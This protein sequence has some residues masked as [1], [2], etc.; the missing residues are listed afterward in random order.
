M[1]SLESIRRRSGLL[2]VV[3]GVGLFGFLG[4]D[5]MSSQR[6]GGSADASVGEVYGESVDIQSFEARVQEQVN[7]QKQNNPD[8]DV[9]Q[10]RNSIW[11]QMVRELVM[12]KEYEALG[13][14]VG[15]DELFDMIQGNNPNASVKQ[16]FTDPATGAFDRARLLQYLKEDID[17][18]VTGQ[19]RARWIQFE[20]ALQQ[21]RQ[22][23]KYNSLVA[24]GLNVSDF[25]AQ[26]NYNF[27]NEVRNASYI[28]IPLKT[29]ADSLVDVS[30]SELSDYMY[31]NSDRFQQDASRAVEYVVFAV[32]PSAADDQAALAWTNDIKAEFA[33][34][35]NNEA[36]LRRYSDGAGAPLTYVDKE[37]LAANVASLFTA[38]EGTV[39]GPFKQGNR[40]Y[41][42]AKLVASA[43]RPDSVEARHIL[44]TGANAEAVADSLK[45]LIEGGR[46]FASL[47]EANSQDPGSAAKGGDLGWFAEGLM[48]DEFNEA[49][50][51]AK[52][53]A[54]Q[55][56]NSQFGTH[57]IEV[58]AKSRS[59]KKVK[60]AY[61]DRKVEPS[62]ETYSG[63]FTQAGKFA[64]E[65]TSA[66]QF[67]ETVSAENL[68]KRIADNLQ[69]NTNTITG[70]D[71]PRALVRW[72]YEANIGEVSDVFTFANK[73]VIATLTEINEE[74]MQDLEDVRGDITTSVRDQ[75]RV[76]MLKEQLQG[77]SSLE[78]LANDYGVS[79]K[80]V[81]GV[82]FNNNQVAG[83][84]NE[85]A[86]VG[87]TFS[88]EEG[89]TSTPFAGK[90]AVFVV[91]A[92]NVISAPEGATT[93]LKQQ[94]TTALQSR[95][96]YQAYQ[97][98]QDLADVQDNRADF[99]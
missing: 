15:S 77:A 5:F 73:F 98:L 27:Q 28:Q 30:D 76:D 3:I 4:M 60:V 38:T 91:R 32:N 49:C 74:G 46:S 1:V 48:V 92:D 6:S 97:S 67:N 94:L 78:E 52:K 51:T 70:L 86:F 9:S 24:K 47:A 99:Y 65:N 88:L 35:E 75:K 81:E 29:I 42:L 80:T 21:N 37:K 20:Q 90:S 95:A 12:A 41:R 57:L 59:S 11:N 71:N 14:V 82:T 61:L 16:A 55:L 17:N 43:S 8:V 85:P 13:V 23:Q 25:E 34:T 84:G 22:T 69:E 79:V 93:T 72:S 87:A 44:L 53:G 26:A 40:V 66:T 2:M 50:F 83:L 68:S 10:V 7:A 31:E 19:T 64:A 39:V 89:A 54:L 58:T 96:G 36:F 45:N 63:V 62:N 56:V 18:D 33:I